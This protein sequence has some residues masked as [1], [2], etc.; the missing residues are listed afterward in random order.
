MGKRRLMGGAPLTGPHSSRQSH[1]AADHARSKSSCGAASDRAT[2]SAIFPEMSRPVA[3]RYHPAP[4][5]SHTRDVDLYW[6]RIAGRDDHKC[7]S[8]ARLSP[9]RSERPLELL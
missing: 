2:T 6:R 5:E 7:L 4:A 1:V 3:E 9:S 8:N